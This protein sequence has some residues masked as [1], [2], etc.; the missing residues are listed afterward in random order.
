[1]TRSGLGLQE[2]LDAAAQVRDGAVGVAARLAQLLD[3]RFGA[4]HAGQA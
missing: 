2:T 1:V 4:A 3:H